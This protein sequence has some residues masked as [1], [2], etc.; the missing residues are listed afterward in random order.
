MPTSPS[1][2]AGAGG[3]RGAEEAFSVSSGGGDSGRGAA[4]FSVSKVLS[5]EGP[6]Q[7]R[8][9]GSMGGNQA[10]TCGMVQSKQPVQRP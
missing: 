4:V 2:L 9:E 10:E 5:D 3:W 6:S 7:Q 8:L 1:V